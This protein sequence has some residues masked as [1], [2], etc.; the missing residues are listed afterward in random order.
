LFEDHTLIV[1]ERWNTEGVIDL[2]ERHRVNF[3]FMVPTMMQRIARLSGLE[4]RDFSSIEALFHAECL[5]R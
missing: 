3:M 1:M 5:S 4:Q 2:I